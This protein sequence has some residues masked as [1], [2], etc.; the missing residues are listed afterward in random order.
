VSAR[1]KESS[2]ERIPS[3]SRRNGVIRFARVRDRSFFSP[4]R[5]GVNGER[6]KHP[7]ERS[8]NCFPA[9]VSG[10]ASNLMACDSLE[11][12]STARPYTRGFASKVQVVR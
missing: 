1:E 9:I 4:L 12:P 11:S 7:E 3:I 6:R 2:R 10:H 5:S 8:S